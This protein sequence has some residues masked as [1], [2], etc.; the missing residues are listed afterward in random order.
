MKTT[1]A[2]VIMAVLL[3]SAAIA[4]AQGDDLL[5]YRVQAAQLPLTGLVDVWYKL[6]AVDGEPVTVSLFLSTDGGISYPFLCQAVTGDVG[7]GVL[8]GTSRHIVWNAGAD[9]PGFSS[10]ICRLRVTAVDGMPAYQVADLEGVWESHGVAFEGS[11]APWWMWGVDTVA[12]DGSYSGTVTESDGGGG[13]ESGSLALTEGGLLTLPGTDDDFLGALD[14]DKDVFVFTDI[15]AGSADA[16]TVELGVGVR[17]G[18][19]Y[20]MSDLVGRWEDNRMASIPGAPWW[21]RGELLIAA[22]GSFTAQLSELGGS[23]QTKTGAFGG[24]STEGVLSFSGGDP[25]LRMVMDAG[26]TV[27]VGTATWGNGSSPET[28]E[29]SIDVKMAA[30]YSLSDLQGTWQFHTVS[31]GTG[32]WWQRAAVVIGLDGAFSASTTGS[33]GSGTISGLFSITTDGIIAL[34]DAPAF[35]GV[36][37][38]G[39]TVLVSTDIRPDG[40][41]QMMVGLKMIPVD[42]GAFQT[43]TITID[44]EP[45]SINAPWQITGPGGFTSSAY[46]DTTFAI[47]TTGSY[48][49]TWGAATGWTLPSP[50]AST[51][52]L[53]TGGVVTF[54][55]LYAANAGSPDYVS[56]PAGTF[57]M[58]SPT[59]EPERYSSETQHQVTLTHGVYVQTT[60][61][62]N[63]QYRDMAQWAYNNGH[64]TATTIGLYDNLDGSTQLLKALGAGNYEMTFS[65][66]VFSCINPTHPVKYVNWYGSVA[67]CDWL[68]LQQGLPRAYIHSTWECNSGNPY[69]ATGYRLPTEAEWEYACRAGTQ[70][71]FHTGSC[72]DAGTEANY[73]GGYPYTGCPTGPYAVWTMPVGSYPANVF[74]LYDMHGNLW[75]WCNDWYGTYV[76]TVTDPTGPGAGSY[77]VLR[78]GAWYGYAQYCRSALRN[79][80]EPGIDDSSLGFRPVRS[81]N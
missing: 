74:G 67:Y 62:T 69:T 37:D 50:N 14:A 77:R 10:M 38:A 35:R 46:G 78:G 11:G 18:N 33:G 61:V 30:S 40:S 12:S 2:V 45:N 16:G 25:G 3:L 42:P 81:A 49:L 71:P 41:S 68:S 32:A 6:Q 19:S 72:L 44:P 56:I 59:T 55:G 48:T 75:E 58:G 65:G 66:G 34:Q 52:T 80:Y 22:D 43:G 24:I 51:Q 26:K 20:S 23:P 63:Q 13:S 7:D 15:W 60:E 1:R 57:M 21:M 8:P 31:S 27:I 64:V 5:V 70:T 17:R 29:L 47:I 73:N 79:S 54:A 9:F 39:K 4:Q 76:G 53:T 28:A 36:L